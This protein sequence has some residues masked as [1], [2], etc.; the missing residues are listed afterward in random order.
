MANCNLQEQHLM[1]VATSG[2]EKMGLR[3][4]SES[5]DGSRVWRTFSVTERALSAVSSPHW[6]M[7]KLVT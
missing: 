4:V 6:A 1:M 3:V 5:S 2:R 7:E